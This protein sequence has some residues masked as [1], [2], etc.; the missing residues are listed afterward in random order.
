MIRQSSIFAVFA[1]TVGFAVWGGQVDGTIVTG[2]VAALFAAWSGLLGRAGWRRALWVAGA[3]VA[4]AAVLAMA[5]EALLRSAPV[6]PGFGAILSWLVFAPN[7]AVDATGLLCL[8]GEDGLFRFQVS[9]LLL[10]LQVLVPALLLALV[11]AVY[12]VMSVKSWLVVAA[13]IAVAIAHALVMIH[14]WID[15]P[16]VLARAGAT[17][18]LILQAAVTEGALFAV[19]VLVIG[20][21]ARVPDANAASVARVESFRISPV[22]CVCAAICY[23]LVTSPENGERKAPVLLVDDAHSGTWAPSAREMSFEWFGDFSTYN[24]ASICDYLKTDWDVT[25]LAEG[26]LTPERLRGVSALMLKMPRNPYTV[27]EV[28]AVRDFVRQGGGLLLIGDHTDLLGTS[29]HLNQICEP[30]G[31]RFVSN[32]TRDGERGG[33]S[34]SSVSWTNGFPL[35]RSTAALKFMTGCTVEIARKAWP[36]IVARGQEVV[37]HDYSDNNHF[38]NLRSDPSQPHGNVVL[39]AAASHGDGRVVAFTDSTMLSGFAI[40]REGRMGFIEDS[41]EWLSYRHVDTSAWQLALLA[42]GLGAAILGALRRRPIALGGSACIGVV[43]AHAVLV[44][45]VDPSVG[46]ERQRT[47]ETRAGLAIVEPASRAWYPP[48]LGFSGKY[49]DW[50]YDTWLASWLRG[51]VYPRL[52][53]DLEQAMDEAAIAVLNPRA[54]LGARQRDR[55]GEWLRDG[56]HLIVCVRRDQFEPAN[57]RS[58]VEPFVPGF[59]MDVETRDGQQDWQIEFGDMELADVAGPV[60]VWRTRIGEGAI[61]VALGSEEWNTRNLGHCFDVP[62]ESQRL[63]YGALET[64]SGW[65]KATREPG[66]VVK[67]LR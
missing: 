12:R 41:L 34:Q 6:V 21:A 23:M 61:V 53:D 7:A 24:L 55:V 59:G 56:G 64:I 2:W 58:W 67:V 40:C 47:T 50:E 16:E 49:K 39:A 32:Y 8:S 44:A 14:V 31:I 5:N 19:I 54:A 13:A 65:L 26:A 38:G 66:G 30:L 18:N 11:A 62:D 3:L 51:D 37:A 17:Q 4:I 1:A 48:V 45:T 36:I 63:A 10:G 22:V 57:F 33:F 60:E 46:L 15:A 52:V 42:L 29:T 20:F 25:V 27:A 9:S 28:E 43:I 35:A